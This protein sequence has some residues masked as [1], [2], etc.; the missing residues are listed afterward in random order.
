MRFAGFLSFLFSGKPF[1]DGELAAVRSEVSFT[2]AI[3]AHL[4]WKRRLIDAL[5]GKPGQ[6]PNADEVGRDSRCMLGQWIHGTGWE[7]YGDLPSFVELRDE[8]A[9]FHGLAREI[10]E[11]AHAGRQAEATRLM[12]GEFQ[13]TSHDIIARIKHLSGLFGS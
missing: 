4:A 12:E 11:H 7:R 2:A 9:R 6:W 8:H 13:R 1:S 10:V 3:E 5:A